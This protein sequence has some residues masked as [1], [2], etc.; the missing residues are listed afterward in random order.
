MIPTLTNALIF[1]GFA[2]LAT[3][4]SVVTILATIHNATIVG[5]S[6]D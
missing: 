6:D 1:L 2:A 4:L 3:P 5:W